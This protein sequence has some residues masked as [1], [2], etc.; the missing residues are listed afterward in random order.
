M[1]INEHC[2]FFFFRIVLIYDF[3]ARLNFYENSNFLM[4][5]IENII[6]G[7]SF[8]NLCKG[9]QSNF[10]RFFRKMLYLASYLNLSHFRNL[11][12]GGAYI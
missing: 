6:F 5:F 1:N 7:K 10:S 2:P 4:D 12:R 9:S 8:T 3:N 11:S